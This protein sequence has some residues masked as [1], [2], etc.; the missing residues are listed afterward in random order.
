LQLEKQHQRRRDQ[1]DDHRG[2]QEMRAQISQ[3]EQPAEADDTDRADQQHQPL[4]PGD[5]AAIDRN[6]A[7]ARVVKNGELLQRQQL[8][9]AFRRIGR[10]EAA[11]DIHGMHI[12]VA[13]VRIKAPPFHKRPLA[14]DHHLRIVEHIGAYVLA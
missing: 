4:E 9:V 13:G 6:P 12:D 5:A 2:H 10:N 1:R 8:R 7:L 11:C 3:P 14:I